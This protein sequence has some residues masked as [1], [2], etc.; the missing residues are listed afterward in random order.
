MGHLLLMLII[1]PCHTLLVFASQ[2]L[3]GLCM[4]HYD[5]SQVLDVCGDLLWMSAEVRWL[6]L[7]LPLNASAGLLLW[8]SLSQSPFQP[9]S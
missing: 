5:A 4:P 9:G 1:I 6:L 3:S 7:L 2:V 8:R